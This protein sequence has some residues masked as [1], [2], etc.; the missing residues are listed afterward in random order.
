MAEW[1]GRGLQNLLQRFN[2]ASG[3]DE[4]GLSRITRQ[5]LFHGARLSRIT[6]EPRESS[7]SPSA[8]NILRF[9][10]RGDPRSG[11]FSSGLCRTTHSAAT[12]PRRRR[13]S[14][15]PREKQRQRR[16]GR[17]QPIERNP[18]SQM[19][20]PELDDTQQQQNQHGSRQQPELPGAR[21]KRSRKPVRATPPRLRCDGHRAG[22]SRQR[23]R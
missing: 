4:K 16:A 14:S 12:F 6:P 19:H 20:D 8:G 3:L 5:P 17:D 23:A 10:P 2:S 18:P 9:I 21:P 7:V 13:R 1:L 11:Y 22:T 15:Q